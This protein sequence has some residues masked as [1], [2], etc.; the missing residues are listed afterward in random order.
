MKLTT[1][2][3]LFLASIAVAAPAEL[4]RAASPAPV[5]HP[6]NQCCGFNDKNCWPH[7]A[8]DGYC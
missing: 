8:D 6:E 4:K 7:K 1:T 5:V 2:I 3:L